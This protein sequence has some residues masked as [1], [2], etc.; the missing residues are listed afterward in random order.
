MAP[1]MFAVPPGATPNWNLKAVDIWALGVVY[2]TL[3]TGRF[4][5]AVAHGDKSPEFSEYLVGTLTSRYPWQ[6][7]STP[8]LVL[9]KRMLCV[10][11]AK[12]ATIDEVRELLHITMATAMHQVSIVATACSCVCCGIV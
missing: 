1:E 11:A 8:S 2:F 9:I 3:L 5:W 4:P 12:R 10:D 7:I 6:K